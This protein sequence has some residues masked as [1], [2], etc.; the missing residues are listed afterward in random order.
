MPGGECQRRK[1]KQGG[2]NNQLMFLKGGQKSSPWQDDI[3]AER[4][5]KLREGTMQISVWRT[6]IQ[7]LNKVNSMHS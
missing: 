5:G 3:W 6:L 1:I 4:P 7:A 2:R